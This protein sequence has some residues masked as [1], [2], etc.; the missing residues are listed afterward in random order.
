MAFKLGTQDQQW[1]LSV[2]PQSEKEHN[3]FT[4]ITFFW[5]LNNIIVIYS[6]PMFFLNLSPSYVHLLWG[7]L[8]WKHLGNPALRHH[9]LMKD[10]SWWYHL[11]LSLIT[12]R[13]FSHRCSLNIPQLS[14]FFFLFHFFALFSNVSLFKF[15]L[16]IYLPEKQWSW[17]GK[18]L[19]ILSLY[20]FEISKTIS[21][22]SHSILLTFYT[23]FLGILG[24]AIR[25]YLSFCSLVV[26]TY[27]THH[28][29]FVW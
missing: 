2:G 13:T 28:C 4:L 10:R 12:C 17:W 11:L 22:L 5:K 1:T 27:S 25:S 23:A 9:V 6:D 16:S 14:L 24:E 29:T 19:H 3:I 20:C 21:K 15:R 18:T 26:G 8:A 7:S